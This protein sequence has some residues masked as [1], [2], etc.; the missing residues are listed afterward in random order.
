MYAHLLHAPP[1]VLLYAGP[2]VWVVRP[3]F[4]TPTRKTEVGFV[5]M[6]R[7]HIVE[8]AASPD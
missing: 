7:D 5:F 3:C 2:G 8:N 1:H 4:L 6:H